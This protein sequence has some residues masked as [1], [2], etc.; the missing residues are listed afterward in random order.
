VSSSPTPAASPSATPRPVPTPERDAVDAAQAIR[1]LFERHTAAWDAK[2]P[3]AI[4]ALYAAEV[5]FV[6][7]LGGWPDESRASLEMMVRGSVELQDLGSSAS[8][9]FVDASGG[10]E[11]YDVWG[12]GDATEADPVHEV[13]VFATDGGLL[14]A[15]TTVYDLKSLSQITHIPVAQFAKVETMLQG[16]AAA[17][18]S[19]D[20]TSIAALYAE[21]ASRT[22]MLFGE[23]AAGRQA[24]SDGANRSFSSFAGAVWQLDLPFGDGAGQDAL[25]G[26]TFTVRLAQPRAC[27]LGAA[28][29]VKTN[30]E[31]QI[32]SERVYWELDSLLRCGLLAGLV[33]RG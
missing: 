30:P 3:D 19:R 2:D 28:V 24:I 33:T 13:D 5:R 14:T 32:V 10:V 15:L 17:W 12:L 6:D 20:L 21:G 1:S 25:S 4:L 31:Q 26:G 7:Y 9:Y 29:V 23:L 18:S 22:D 16:Y 8:T 11:S 27:E